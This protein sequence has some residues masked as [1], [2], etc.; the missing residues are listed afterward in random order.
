MLRIQS[1]ERRAL[2]TKQRLLCCDGFLQLCDDIF[3]CLDGGGSGIKLPLQ[4]LCLLCR[5]SPQ[6]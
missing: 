4:P 1:L 2:F 5:G 6:E 3:L